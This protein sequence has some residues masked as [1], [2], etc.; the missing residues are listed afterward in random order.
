M[1]CNTLSSFYQ[2]SLA[3][4]NLRSVA[5]T[6]QVRATHF[7]KMSEFCPKTES[8]QKNRKSTYLNLRAKIQ[9]LHQFAQKSQINNFSIFLPT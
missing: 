2:A 6:K 4:A 8:W 9:N 7:F 5:T 3:S 1:I